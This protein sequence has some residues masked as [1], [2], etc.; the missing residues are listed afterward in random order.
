MAGAAPLAFMMIGAA[1]VGFAFAAT[2]RRWPGQ[3]RP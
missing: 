3:A 2:R 1:D